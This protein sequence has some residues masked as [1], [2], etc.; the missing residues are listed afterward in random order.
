MMECGGVR[1]YLPTFLRFKKFLDVDIYGYVY[2]FIKK[3]YYFE[4]QWRYTWYLGGRGDEEYKIASFS[5]Q[6]S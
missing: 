6:P 5:H 2:V 3:R 1:W 4:L